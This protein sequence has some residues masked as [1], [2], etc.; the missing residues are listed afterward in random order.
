MRGGARNEAQRAGRPGKPG[1]P[2]WGAGKIRLADAARNLCEDLAK[3][4]AEK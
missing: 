2:H 3:V 4:G 1:K